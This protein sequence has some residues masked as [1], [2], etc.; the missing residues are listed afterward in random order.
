[1]V[2]RKSED[3]RYDL[4]FCMVSKQFHTDL[5]QLVQKF[6]IEG[7]KHVSPVWVRRTV[8]QAM[9]DAADTMDDL[10]WQ[11]EHELENTK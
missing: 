3:P 1:M 9:D 6:L 4:A 5:E 8:R 7:S 10:D 11:E 2:G